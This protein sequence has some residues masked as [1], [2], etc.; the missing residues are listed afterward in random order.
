MMDSEETSESIYHP[1]PLSFA[2]GF[3]AWIIHMIGRWVADAVRKGTEINSANESARQFFAQFYPDSQIEVP[4]EIRGDA[5]AFTSYHKKRMLPYL[6]AIEGKVF[7]RK[8]FKTN[9]DLVGMGL[10]SIQAGDAVW[11]IR[12][13]RTPLILRPKPGTEDFTLVGE[14]YLHG[15]MHGEML[16]SRWDLAK[17]I[18]PV[19]LV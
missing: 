18:G 4:E 1:P 3:Q 17:H 9:N 16:D 6:H 10:R 11:L 5:E 7:G 13:S 2:K 8:L 12:D 14:A 15:F 19:T